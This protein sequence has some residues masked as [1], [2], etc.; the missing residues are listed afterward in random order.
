MTL[1]RR[2]AH[3][4][5]PVGIGVSRGQKRS[6][7]RIQGCMA[8]M[9]RGI[10][11]PCGAWRRHGARGVLLGSVLGRRNGT[12]Q[13][14]GIDRLARRSGLLVKLR[15]EQ[16]GRII[17]GSGSTTRTGGVLVEGKV[18]IG[19]VGIEEIGEVFLRRH[20]H[21]GRRG[22]FQLIEEACFE[23][24]RNAV[25]GRKITSGVV[26]GIS[27][28]RAGVLD[29]GVGIIGIKIR[30]RMRRGAAAFNPRV[31]VRSHGDVTISE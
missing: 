21:I 2:A 29:V 9:L 30:M 27:A 10:V 15:I 14:G 4:R 19:L 8:R 11:R 5:L 12:D 3:H 18:E 6:G 20:G 1:K 31:V 24:L 28:R 16:Q 26:V 17:L 13:V 22:L 25:R 23:G 7:R